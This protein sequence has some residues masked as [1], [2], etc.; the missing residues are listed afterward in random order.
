[1]VSPLSLMKLLQGIKRGTTTAHFEADKR[2]LKALVGSKPDA[3]LYLRWPRGFALRTV[4]DETH[5]LRVARP[6]DFRRATK[7]TLR[8]TSAERLITG[9]V[10]MSRGR[11]AGVNLDRVDPGAPVQSVG[12]H[13]QRRRAEMQTDLPTL[14]SRDRHTEEV[15]NKIQPG[16]PVSPVHRAVSP[17]GSLTWPVHSL[18]SVRAYPISIGGNSGISSGGLAPA[19]PML[20]PTG[21]MALHLLFQHPKGRMNRCF[22]C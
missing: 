11:F 16:L 13:R 14:L 3:A 15:R 20:R 17:G 18:F 2:K 8:A 22:Y 10:P 6:A 1:V 12:R 4:L 5:P 19:T 21:Q 7:I 9:R